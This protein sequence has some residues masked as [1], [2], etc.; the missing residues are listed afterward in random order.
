MPFNFLFGS[1]ETLDP[2]RKSHSKVIDKY[3]AM[4][5]PSK[6]AFLKENIDKEISPFL[7]SMLPKIKEINNPTIYDIPCGYGRHSVYLA[8]QGFRVI[9]IDIDRG[10]INYLSEFSKKHK[11][12]NINPTLCD[13]DNS[14]WVNP[15]LCD[16]IINIHLYKKE[17]L[18]LFS[19]LLSIGGLLLIETPSSY[20]MNYMELPLKNEI[21]E[22]LKEHFKFIYYKEHFIKNEKVSVKLLA[23]KFKA[24]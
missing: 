24:Q 8:Y 14:D 9:G 2:N 18:S 13:I 10:A 7:K 15:N 1:G 16:V 22:N 6:I 20:G 21:K 4:P 19:S 3:H 17:Y 23:Q 5:I 11:L 12:N